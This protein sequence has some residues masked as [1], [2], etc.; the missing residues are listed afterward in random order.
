VTSNKRLKGEEL[1]DRIEAFIKAQGFRCDDQQAPPPHRKYRRNISGLEI[2]IDPVF[3]GG[4]RGRSK[5]EYLFVGVYKGKNLLTIVPWHPGKTLWLAMK[6]EFQGETRAKERELRNAEEAFAETKRNYQLC[7][8]TLAK[9]GRS[10][11]Y[12]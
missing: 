2:V 8:R 12:G 1:W 7:V 4:P 3:V 9:W 10:L 5:F 6:Q 11:T